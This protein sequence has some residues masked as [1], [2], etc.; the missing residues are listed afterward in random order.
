MAYLAEAGACRS[1]DGYWY[2]NG[3]RLAVGPIES[4]R[5]LKDRQIRGYSAGKRVVHTR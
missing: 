5:L 2:H 3:L 4:C 1:A